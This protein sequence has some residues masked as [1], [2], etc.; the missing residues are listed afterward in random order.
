MESSIENDQDVDFNNVDQDNNSFVLF[1]NQFLPSVEC[2]AIATES[3]TSENDIIQCLDYL[4][5]DM[6]KGL[7]IRIKTVNKV[8]RL[9]SN[10]A[11]LRYFFSVSLFILFLF[12]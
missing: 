5:S 4:D 2:E 11:K 10:N 1:E 12:N 3:K 7:K 8:L 9:V 6:E